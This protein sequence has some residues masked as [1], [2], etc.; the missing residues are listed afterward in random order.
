MGSVASHSV[1]SRHWRAAVWCGLPAV[2]LCAVL[3]SC[4]GGGPE[5]PSGAGRLVVYVYW[6]NQ[7]LSQKQVEV[8]E[9]H[10]VRITNDRG[11]AEFVV[12]AGSYTLRAYDINRGGP[13]LG[14]VDLQTNIRIGE[15]TRIEVFDCLLCVASQ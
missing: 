7:G 13:S 1:N 14:Y 15:T 5:N 3:T 9:L 4:K 12:P 6:N 2:L 10:E 8:V 11:L